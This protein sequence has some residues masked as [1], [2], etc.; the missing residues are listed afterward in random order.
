[1]LRFIPAGI[2]RK[3]WYLSGYSLYVR[4]LPAHKWRSDISI[5]G[6]KGHEGGHVNIVKL[7]D[8]DVYIISNLDRKSVV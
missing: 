1:M 8:R 3:N 6:M 4:L 5:D 2:Y 7:Y